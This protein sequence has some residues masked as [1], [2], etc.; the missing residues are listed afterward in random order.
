MERSLQ[1]MGRF[2]VGADDEMK[3]KKIDYWR[4]KIRMY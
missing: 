1:E 2:A 4:V 3:W